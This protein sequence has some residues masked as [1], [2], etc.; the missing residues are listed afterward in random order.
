MGRNMA[1]WSY[2]VRNQS[3]VNKM[4]IYKSNRSERVRANDSSMNTPTPTE[5]HRK[6][7]RDVIFSA[8]DGAELIADSEARAVAA[9]VTA[10]TCVHHNDKQREKC[11]VCLVTTITAERDHWQKIAVSAS[12]EREHNANVAQAMTA[13]GRDAIARAERAEAELAT[14][15]ERLRSEAMDDYAAIKDLQRELAAERAR[16]D[17]LAESWDNHWQ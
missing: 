15:K 12:Q 9:A 17:W 6:L 1:R 10:L 7:C 13:E 4:S 11:P 8:T 16:L 5:A 14:A 2:Y 3:G